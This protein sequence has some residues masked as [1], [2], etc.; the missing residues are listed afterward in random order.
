MFDGL[1]YPNLS[2]V[3]TPYYVSG[4]FGMAGNVNLLETFMYLMV[5]GK[6]LNET[7]KDVWIKT[8][9]A[10]KE[11]YETTLYTSGTIRGQM[12]RMKKVQDISTFYRE[13]NK[14]KKDKEVRDLYHKVNSYMFPKA[15]GSTYVDLST[16]NVF[17]LFNQEVA[18]E[19]GELYTYSPKMNLRANAG[20]GYGKPGKS[21]NKQVQLAAQLM[22]YEYLSDLTD[23]VSGRLAQSNFRG[24][25]KFMW[26]SYLNAKA[27][28][29]LAS[30][31]NEKTRNIFIRNSAA[32]LIPKMVWTRYLKTRIKFRSA[33]FVY[34]YTT[35]KKTGSANLSGFSPYKG[36]MAFISDLMDRCIE[37]KDA[38]DVRVVCAIY[39]DNAFTWT[40]GKGKCVYLFMDAEKSE[41]SITAGKIKIWTQEHL[42][43]YRNVHPAIKTHM[44]DAFPQMAAAG[45]TVFGNQQIK[46]NSM[47]SGVTGTGTFNSLKMGENY[48]VVLTKNIIFPNEDGNDIS[49]NARKAFE[50]TGTKMRKEIV[51]NMEWVKET[52][53]AEMRHLELLGFDAAKFEVG[54][55]EY[56]VLPVLHRDRLLRT[57]LHRKTRNGDPLKDKVLELVHWKVCYFLGGW[58]N[59][60]LAT[61]IERG[62]R[63]ALKTLKLLSYAEGEGAQGRVLLD[64]FESVLSMWDDP[65]ESGMVA[66][67]E[68]CLGQASLPSVYDLVRIGSGDEQLAL[69]A[70][71]YWYEVK[72]FPPDM[73]FTPSLIKEKGIRIES[74]DDETDNDVSPFIIT[75]ESEEADL[76]KVAVTFHEG[77][78]YDAPPSPIR[79]KMEAVSMTEPTI[80][81]KYI[82]PKKIKPERVMTEEE[83]RKLQQWMSNTFA[84]PKRYFRV[85]IAEG[86]IYNTKSES[87]AARNYFLRMLA[88]YFNTSKNQIE[89]NLSG[90]QLKTIRFVFS[91]NSIPAGTPVQ[92]VT[93]GVTTT[94]EYITDPLS[95]SSA[96]LYQKIYPKRVRK[97]E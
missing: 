19:D 97:K 26:L 89:S 65:R 67:I 31:I 5:E 14:F 85:P 62:S 58:S 61:V 84:D 21:T 8:Y 48:I 78:E 41:G 63:R 60:P 56:T 46:N 22:A 71:T 95:L 64:D 23:V 36:G 32:D 44:V 27:E 69:R 68:Y 57:L 96:D 42:K 53:E 20:P 50:S 59:T 45:I 6:V 2:K 35:K 70:A 29:Y 4:F 34:N 10:L 47:V 92:R 73:C 86:L 72:E 30:E 9:A 3:R 81:P 52:G 43:E 87:S 33:P 55:G 11:V 91:R 24:K 66:L 40:Y 76:Q 18:D 37:R 1:Y 74:G 90:N 83:I 25:W 82:P 80:D 12:G 93:D 49:K 77:P 28:V 15:K 39:A 7:N 51:N 94:H 38:D 75:M 88:Q 79:L 16:I 13:N 17:N 54:D